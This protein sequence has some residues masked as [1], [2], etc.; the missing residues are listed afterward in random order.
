MSNESKNARQLAG[1]AYRKVGGVLARG[2]RHDAELQAALL[3]EARGPQ[4]RVLPG[5]VGVQRDLHDPVQRRRQGVEHL[6]PPLEVD[7]RLEDPVAP[8]A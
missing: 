8:V 5:A 2:Q 6:R 7:R 3:R 4:H 1:R